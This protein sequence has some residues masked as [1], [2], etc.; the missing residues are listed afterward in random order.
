MA[1][2]VLL[3]EAAIGLWIWSVWSWRLRQETSFR[4]LG[5]RNL[6]QEFQTYGYP[7]WVFKAVGAFKTS[8]ASMLVLSIII[9]MRIITLIG[10][11]GM[12]VLMSV[13]V[14][15]HAKVGDPLTKYVPA[16]SM[17]TCS[18][19]ILWALSAGCIVDSFEIDP[20]RQGFGCL[21]AVT[22]FAMWLRSFMNSDY[23]IDSYE[24]LD[25]NP[26][27]FLNA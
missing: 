19:Y 7:I 11:G 27:V 1:I 9:P 15:S 5:A 18:V 10:A 24:K 8:F 22:C 25:E 2:L 12:C 13:A 6:L 14:V 4:G 26:K 16:V 23:N 17:L 3:A 21:V 20:L